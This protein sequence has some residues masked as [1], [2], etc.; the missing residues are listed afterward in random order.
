[1]LVRWTRPAAGDLRC[2]ARYIRRDNPTAA[3]NVATAIF[4]AGNSLNNSPE[5]GRKG[6]IPGTRELVFP[7]WPYILVYE[8]TEHTVQILRIYHGAQDW[9]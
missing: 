3:R 9:P 2:I 6:R 8:I 1:M 5:R 4:N 7:G